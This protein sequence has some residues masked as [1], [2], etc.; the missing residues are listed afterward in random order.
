M[1]DRIAIRFP[2]DAADPRLR[3]LAL[4]VD[5]GW[6]PWLGLAIRYHFRDDAVS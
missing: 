4:D 6:V 2:A 3:R 5:P 1:E